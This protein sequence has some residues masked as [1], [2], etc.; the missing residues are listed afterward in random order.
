MEKKSI[1]EIL[2]ILEKEMNIKFPSLYVR[3]LS[4]EVQDKEPY[5]LITEKEEYIYIYNIYDIQERNDVY[6]IQNIEPNYFLIGQDGDIGYFI[7]VKK[8]NES[9]NIYSLDLGALGSL[10]MNKEATDIYHLG[11]YIE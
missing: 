8:N 1:I 3:F 2:Y 10:E 5:E 11:K 6:S 9:D 4:E 7:Y